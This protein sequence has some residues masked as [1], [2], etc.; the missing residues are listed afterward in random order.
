MQ[1]IA[2]KALAGCFK[3]GMAGCIVG[4][5]IGAAATVANSILFHEVLPLT[6]KVK[7]K[8]IVFRMSSLLSEKKIN[9]DVQ[10]LSTY[11]HCAPNL[12]DQGARLTQR[13]ID[14]NDTFHLVREQGKDGVKELAHLV[15]VAKRADALWRGLSYA[16]KDANDKL[17]AEETL[18]AALNIHFSFEEMIAS[19]RETFRLA[20][21]IADPN[22]T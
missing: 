21:N 9:E 17:G 20:P 2:K 11:Q 16:V 1:A 18:Q 8:V 12:Y 6:Y 14:I 19:M 10:T 4:L 15:S 3:G 22:T 13:A 7:G 5:C